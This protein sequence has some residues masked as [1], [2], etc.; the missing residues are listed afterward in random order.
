[1]YYVYLLRSKR[2]NFNYIGST[3]NLDKR[4]LEHNN[5][6]NKPT[7]FYAPFKL[8]YYEAYASKK[9]ALLR[10]S[11]LKHHGSV[12]GHLKRRLAHSFNE[13]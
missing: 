4:F 8:I 2:H 9:D 13:I 3:N 5:G 12:I 11:K 6:E 7:K 10:E 1:M